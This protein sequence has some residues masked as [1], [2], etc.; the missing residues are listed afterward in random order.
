MSAGARSSTLLLVA[1]APDSQDETAVPIAVRARDT[2]GIPV[3][4]PAATTVPARVA[5]L[6]RVTG[7]QA[8]LRLGPSTDY[9]VVKV[10][11][12][13]TIL[14]ISGQN[15]Q[16][17]WLRIRLPEGN[18]GWI[19]RLLTDFA[20]TVPVLAAPPL[21]QATPD[22]VITEWRGEYYRQPSA[23]GNA[24]PRSQ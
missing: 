8:N 18:D 14:N 3:E 13:G 2:A 23:G 11:T 22:P 19:L 10:F 21:A 16:G 6:A 15:S 20:D 9:P 17:D 7:Q 12:A 24:R 5:G 4:T 1:R